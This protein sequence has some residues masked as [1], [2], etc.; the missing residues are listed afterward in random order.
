M[1]ISLFRLY[2]SL[3]CL[4]VMAYP[5]SAPQDPTLVQRPAPRPET[6]AGKIQLDVVVRGKQGTPISGLELK[7]FSILDDKKSQTILSF[8]AIDRASS[9]AAPERAVEVILLLDLV[10]ET[11]EQAS[12]MRQQIQK[13]LEQA[14]GHLSYPTS[15]MVLAEDGLR[16]QRRPSTDANA[17]SAMLDQ[18]NATAHTTGL[19]EIGRFQLSLRSLA[20]IAENETKSP[21]RKILIWTG[22][23]WPVPAGSSVASSSQDRQRTFDTIVEI[24]TRMREAHLSLYSISPSSAAKGPTAGMASSAPY[25]LTPYGTA[26]VAKANPGMNDASDASSYRE[27]LRGVKSP[28]Q[29]NSG[30]LALQVFAV[31][32]GGRVLDPTNDL[33]GQIASCVEDLSA[34]YALSFTPAPANHTGEY[35]D[36]K[37]Q[38]AKPGLGARTITGY[39]N[40]P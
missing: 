40:Q 12:I 16:V 15:I 32:S 39:Y 5:Q 30:S 13:Y 6:S 9:P 23:G 21:S 19:G 33:T 27:F 25:T 35:H 8:Q 36:L 3:L 20:S 29:A 2:V 11:F 22:P 24:S 4:P 7:D 1:R 18:A 10:N 28:Q 34:F 26:Q 37:V 14:S 31:Q 17:L 38:I